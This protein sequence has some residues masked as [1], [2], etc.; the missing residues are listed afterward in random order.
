LQNTATTG[1]ADEQSAWSST[2][3]GGLPPK[4]FELQGKLYRKAKEEPGFRFYSLFGL[5][6]RRDVLMAASR[7][8][9]A[10][11]NFPTQ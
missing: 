11:K 10:R 4:L 1:D 9:V 3:A 8:G 6:L 5:M 7:V 2:N